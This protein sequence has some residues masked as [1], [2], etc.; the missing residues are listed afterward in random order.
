VT[1][2]K[3]RVVCLAGLGVLSVAVG[4]RAQAPDPAPSVRHPQVAAPSPQVGHGTRSADGSTES[5]SHKAIELHGTKF[6]LMASSR[7]GEVETEEY[8]VEGE[9]AAAW[10]QMLTYQRVTLPAPMPADVYVTLLKRHLE[11]RPGPPK[12]RTVQQGK[13]ASIFG[14]HYLPGDAE[15]EQFGL[16]LVTIPDPRRPN[17]V[18]I[19]QYVCKPQEIAPEDLQLYARRWQARFQSQAA[20]VKR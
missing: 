14:V 3:F 2:S 13:D 1:Q 11:S 8:L 17:E 19:L 9:N 5:S 12:F 7:V 4:M 20:S 6:L 18:H 16:A 15:R 10:T